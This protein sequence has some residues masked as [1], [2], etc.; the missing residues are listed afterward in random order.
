MIKLHII[1]FSKNIG[2]WHSQFFMWLSQK[3]ETHPL[4]AWALT[5]W[6]LYEIFEHIALPT[7]AILWGMGSIG[8]K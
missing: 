8:I 2:R 3:A 7:I 1:N 5:F 6:A 4:W